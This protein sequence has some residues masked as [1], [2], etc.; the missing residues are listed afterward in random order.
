LSTSLVAPW[1]D[2]ALTRGV[3]LEEEYHTP[4]CY[5]VRPAAA[6]TKMNLFAEETLFFIFYA[7]PRDALQEFAAQEL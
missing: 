7:C 3:H 5:N 4:S 6:Q 2:P 1:A